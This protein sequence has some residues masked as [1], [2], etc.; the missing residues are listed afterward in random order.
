MNSCP[1]IKLLHRQA[2]GSK[3]WFLQSL[4]SSSIQ[5]E[6]VCLE[7]CADSDTGLI[8]RKRILERC[9]KLPKSDLENSLSSGSSKMTQGSGHLV[10]C[11]KTSS[12]PSAVENLP[13][14]I[15]PFFLAQS[16]DNSKMK[17]T[18][19]T[20]D[21][22]VSC[23]TSCAYSPD[24]LC[25]SRSSTNSPYCMPVVD[26]QTPYLHT[27]SCSTCH[28]PSNCGCF[29]KH[30]AVESCQDCQYS[31]WQH[32]S[33]S[34]SKAHTHSNSNLVEQETNSG[35][36]IPV[37]ISCEFKEDEI[38]IEELYRDKNQVVCTLKEAFQKH[39]EP[40]IVNL[41]QDELDRKAAEHL[42]SERVG[43]FVVWFLLAIFF[44]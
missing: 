1:T 11:S 7:D 17:M 37:S 35:M 6:P 33:T 40:R 21:P 8:E 42:V 9:S 10:K 31:A 3:S 22:T 39:I 41:P 19:K 4:T 43:F 25:D 16:S 30:A 34:T 14:N 32:K 29:V 26:Q 23:S 15:C 27:H 36:A 24:S 28:S 38:K 13:L 5:F 20:Q 44:F 12:C 18:S 2:G